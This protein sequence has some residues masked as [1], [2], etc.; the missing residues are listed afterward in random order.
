MKVLIVD[1]EP[2]AR[3][4]LVRLLAKIHPAASAIEAVNGHQAL[5]MVEAHNP[6]LLLLDVKMPGMDGIEVAAHLAALPAPP[7]VVFCTAYDE[8]ALQALQHQ[9]VAYLLKPVREDALA[10][11]LATAG[12]VNRLQ[13]ASLQVGGESDGARTHVSCQSHRGFQTL[14]VAEVRIFLAEQKY[15]TACSAETELLI[16]DTLKDLEREY[17]SQFIRVRR[18][19]LVAVQYIERLE[20][21]ADGYWRV[22]LSGLETTPVVSRRHLPEVKQRIAQR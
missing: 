14:E 1:D 8:F 5:A 6:D 9:A 12:R 13:L 15:V 22:V 18:N 16:P 19:T 2:L 10:K 7:A 11:A 4:R 3:A 21:T 20:R 17:A